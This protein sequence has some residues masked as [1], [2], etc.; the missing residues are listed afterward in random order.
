MLVL[1]DPA[2]L[3]HIYVKHNY[4][5]P[6][7]AYIQSRLGKVLGRSVVWAQGL[8]VHASMRKMLNPIFTAE[9]TRTHEEHIVE[10]ADR[11]NAKLLEHLQAQG[12]SAVIDMKQ[13]IRRPTLDVIGRAGFN[14]DFCC[15]ESQD[16][17]E[18]CEVFRAQ[19]KKNITIKGVM[20][21]AVA[22]LYPGIFDLPL[23][24][25]KL[26][27]FTRLRIHQLARNY[28]YR[29]K[30]LLGNDLLSVLLRDSVTKG[31][32]EK[33][34]AQL[35][36]HT[37]TFILTGFETTAS[38]LSYG[39]WMLAKHPKVQERLR[40]EVLS[41]SGNPNFDDLNGP[42]LPY[43]DAV[44]KETMRIFHVN[45]HTERQASE[46]DV[47]P[48]RFPVRSADG[49]QVTSIPIKKGQV[50]VVPGVSV[51][52]L[53]CVWG[54]DA[55]EWRPERWLDP[56][57]LP[58]SST[59]N[60]GWARLFTFSQGPKSCLGFRLA[61]YEWKFFVLSLIRKFRFMDTGVDIVRKVN[62]VVN[63]PQPIIVGREEEGPK[64]PIQLVAL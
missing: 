64:L 58:A 10:A 24:A 34:M 39:L 19:V 18:I 20:R 43:L 15:G 51:D 54:A 31:D 23:P 25:F 1:A 36:E 2:A 52:R 5:Y 62:A 17:R 60:S 8:D 45:G 53:E 26:M 63:I 59:M 55:A 9:H 56:V 35:L 49:S 3:S 27:D 46:D 37:T 22:R 14:H 4:K 42:A 28:L 32:D 30:Q 13:W 47:I 11:F 57:Q 61:L 50:I 12:G 44:C 38:A 6:H 21:A 33:A 48:L 41:F 40:E 7:S 29:D 16:G